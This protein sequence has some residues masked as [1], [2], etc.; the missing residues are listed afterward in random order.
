MRHTGTIGVVCGVGLLTLTACGGGGGG[1]GNP[2]NDTIVLSGDDLFTSVPQVI[3]KSTVRVKLSPAQFDQTEVGEYRLQLGEFEG[4]NVDWQPEIAFTQLSADFYQFK[5]PAAPKDIQMPVL[6]TAS[7]TAGEPVQK[8]LK[9]AVS[10]IDEAPLAITDR[11]V[12]QKGQTLTV[13]AN[14]LGV[15]ANDLDE[16]ELLAN[17]EALSAHI[18]I[19]PAQA[20]GFSLNADGSFSYYADPASTLTEDSFSYRAYDGA[21]YSAD[22]QVRFLIVEANQ[23]PSAQSDSYTVNEGG[24]LTILTSKS[25]LNNDSDPEGGDLWVRVTDEPEAAK[26]GNFS[27]D[28]RT[29]TFH[30]QHDGGEVPTD[31]FKYRVSDGVNESEEVT[32]TLNI[33]AVNDVPVAQS[34]HYSL[35]E[36]V[37]ERALDVLDNDS[38]PEQQPLSLQILA[39]P[40]QGQASVSPDQQHILYTPPKEWSGQTQLTYQVRD[41]EGATASAEVTIEVTAVND[42]PVAS[43]DRFDQIQE[44]GSFSVAAADGVLQNDQDP[45]GNVITAELVAAPKNHVGQ[46]KLNADGSFDYQHDGD[47]SSRDT[48][49]Y[50]ASDGQVSSQTVTVELSISP[51]N[52]APEGRS[53]SFVATEGQTLSVSAAQGVLGNDRDVDDQNLLAQLVSGPQRSQAFNLNSNGSFS[54]RPNSNG[55]GNDGFV[56]RVFDGQ[57]YSENVQVSIQIVNG[58]GPDTRQGCFQSN[59]GN[60]ELRGELSS[61]VGGGNNRYQVSRQAQYGSVDIDFN[62]GSF[63]Y[64]SDTPRRGYLDTFYF[65]VDNQNGG[66]TEQRVDVIYGVKRIMPVGDSITYGVEGSGGAPGRDFAVS[67]RRELAQLFDNAGIRFDFVGSNQSGRNRMSD[68]QHEGWSGQTSQWIANRMTG[69]LDN[70]PADIVLLH[71]GTNDHSSSVDGVRRI[72]DSI[73]NWESANQMEVDVFVAKIIDQRS[74]APFNRAQPAFNNNLEPLVRNYDNAEIVD[75]FSALDPEVDLTP[76]SGDSTGLHPNAAGYTKMGRRWYDSLNGSGVLRRCP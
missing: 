12:V 46:F 25:V 59:T 42:R 31:S 71:I 40:D 30:Y 76:A 18:Q 13:T 23:P 3:E 41:A 36:D 47:E 73:Q 28:G 52:D 51:V 49:T 66:I 15:L 34:D 33:N 50:R 9:L 29:G 8:V 74:D 16:P 48:F 64:R 39:S 7:P 27:L 19:P 35:P 53:D 5:V 65:T 61:L 22:V 38:D 56:Y 11:Y 75:Q 60:G 44:G 68:I 67:Y 17:R 37:S 6:V 58:R 4:P 72:L 63:S 20:D 45:E 26:D 32:V 62:S 14:G 1:N 54:Y 55:S 24:V 2:A 43:V 70:N 69:F 10:A 21:L 57:A